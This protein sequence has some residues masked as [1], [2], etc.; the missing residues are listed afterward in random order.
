[1]KQID[2][3]SIRAEKSP[4]GD[5]IWYVVSQFIVSCGVSHLEEIQRFLNSSDAEALAGL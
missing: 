3:Y 2:N 4:T 5:K 1:M